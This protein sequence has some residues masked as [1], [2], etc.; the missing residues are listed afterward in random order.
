LPKLS[1]FP[2]KFVGRQSSIFAGKNNKKNMAKNLSSCAFVKAAGQLENAEPIKG[3]FLRRQA[4]FHPT[5]SL[6]G[7][8]IDG[9]LGGLSPESAV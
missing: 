6:P 1:L 3:N 8:S 2:R 4:N 9:S 5:L 7:W